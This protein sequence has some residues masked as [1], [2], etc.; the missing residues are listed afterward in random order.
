MIKGIF[1]YLGWT[2]ILVSGISKESCVSDVIGIVTS[3]KIN[4][5]SSPAVCVNVFVVFSSSPVVGEDSGAIA[6]KMK[7]HLK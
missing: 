1:F 7:V 3:P 2:V 4:F 5:R 6:W